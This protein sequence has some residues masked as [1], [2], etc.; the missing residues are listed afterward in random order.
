MTEEQIKAIR[1]REYYNRRVKESFAP[2]VE[3]ESSD[4]DL[5]S[6]GTAG[7]RE[8]LNAKKE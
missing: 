4:E 7:E 1:R 8:K 5:N 6:P 2:N 3:R